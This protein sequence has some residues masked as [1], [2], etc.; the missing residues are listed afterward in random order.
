M[1][2]LDE[3]TNH[4]DIESREAL[5]DALR[6][7]Q[8]A[9]LLVSHDRALL[10]AVGTR[11]VAVEDRRAAQLRGRLAGVRARARRATGHCGRRPA[12]MRAGLDAH[13]RLQGPRMRGRSVGRMRPTASRRMRRL[14]QHQLLRR[15]PVPRR[16]MR[17]LGHAQLKR[18]PP[19]VQA[20]AQAEGR[21]VPPRTA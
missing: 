14:E 20:Q 1:L 8:G 9:V 5:E 7:F 19:G 12:R 17:R 10:D 4:L 16:R 13:V 2:I 18:R 11:T 15:T 6:A 21:R 3:P